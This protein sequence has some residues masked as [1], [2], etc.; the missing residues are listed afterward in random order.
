VKV[1][2][3]GGRLTAIVDLRGR[4]AGTVRVRIRG[5]TRRGRRVTSSRRYR[6]CA[7]RR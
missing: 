3:R 5:V 4:P 1:R 6:L 7:T 2:R